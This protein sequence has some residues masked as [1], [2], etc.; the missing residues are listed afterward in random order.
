[1]FA[2]PNLEDCPRLKLAANLL[3]LKSMR[4]FSPDKTSTILPRRWL[5][6]LAGIGSFLAW[7]AQV[8]AEPNAVLALNSS[9]SASELAHARS[10][11]EARTNDVEAAWRYARACYESARWTTNRAAK[12]KTA[13]Q[14]IEISR[15]LVAQ[16]PDLAAGHYYLSLNLGEFADTKR[17]LAALRMVREME[18]EFKKTVEL[19]EDFDYA[20]ADR[21]LGLLYQQAPTFGSVG[22]RSKA[23]QHF[24]RAL[25][26][27]P[28]FPE[29]RLVLIEADLKWGETGAVHREITALEKDWADARLR[30]A[31]PDWEP[32]WS[33]WDA[34][35]TVAKRKSAA[36]HPPA[37]SPR[38]K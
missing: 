37:Q 19:D 30:F 15:W 12:A 9:R 35:L 25:E 33:D 22:S 20:G 18:R 3:S 11:Y 16:Q 17:N 28:E 36:S 31:G 23:R 27:A 14:G 32:T 2:T 8:M 26:L 1:M 5:E 4:R 38:N 21:A 10:H 13:Q 6:W 34:R 29:N 24:R 7:S